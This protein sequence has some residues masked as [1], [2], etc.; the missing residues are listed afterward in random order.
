[1]VCQ[2]G[3]MDG[4]TG[5]GE[6]RR[7]RGLAVKLSPLGES[8]RDLARVF[9]A[10]HWKFRQGRDPETFGPPCENSSDWIQPRPKFLYEISIE[11]PR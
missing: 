5:L 1:M 2:A 4:W 6:G 10:N 11:R 9:T 7:S 8:N 3:R